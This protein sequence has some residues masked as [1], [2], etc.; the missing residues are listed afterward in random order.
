MYN[1]WHSLWTKFKFEDKTTWAEI[2][3]TIV[4]KVFFVSS[5]ILI[6]IPIIPT[7]GYY[8]VGDS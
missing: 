8:I 3:L 6:I 2:I 4:D 5:P 7:G 1:Y